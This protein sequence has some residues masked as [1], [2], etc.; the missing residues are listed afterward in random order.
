MSLLQMS[1]AGAVMIMAIVVVRALTINLLPKKTFLIL[2]GM[3]AARLLVPVIIPSAFSVY[4]LLDGHVQG[5]G[6]KKVPQTVKGLPIKAS[7]Q[8]SA[9]ADGSL[10]VENTISIWV[11]IWAAGVML[12]VMVF[13]A[14][15]LKCYQE[16]RVS[17]PVNNEFIKNWLD[18]HR[19]RRRICVRQSGRFSTPLTYGIFCPVIL[20]PASVKWGDTKSLEYVLAHEYVHIRRFDSIFKLVLI[21]VLCIHWFNPLVWVMYLLSNRDIELSCDES[22]IRQFGEKTRAE[23]ALLLISMEEKRGVFAPLCSKFSRSAAEE[24]IV[25]IMKYKKVT[26]LSFALG[27]TLVFGVTTAFATT[28]KQSENRFVT[29]EDGSV[30]SVSE[31]NLRGTEQFYIDENGKYT[32]DT[33]R[34]DWMSEF[35][36]MAPEF[37]IPDNPDNNEYSFQLTPEGI[38]GKEQDIL[39][40][41]P[42]RTEEEMQ[43]IIAD[44]ESG[45]IKGYRLEDFESGNVPGFEVPEGADFSVGFVEY[46][47][48]TCTNSGRQ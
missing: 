45:K 25:S 8:I 38:A 24:R 21:M 33:D 40:Y 20:M 2:W 4:S 13:A 17:F 48:G 3:A 19:L 16:F 37:V 23:Y 39:A 15:Y 30:Y 42:L 12:C 22:V 11:V 9:V 44:I 18:N 26:A 41:K 34:V 5:M 29:D 1:F 46:A 6:T 36:I 47:D 14:A 27:F 35:G 31:N 32:R 28:A 7:G 10:T 43:Q